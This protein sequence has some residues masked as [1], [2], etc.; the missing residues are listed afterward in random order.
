M[1]QDLDKVTFQK[2][3]TEKYSIPKNT[4]SKWKKNM[5]KILAGYKKGLDS[6]RIAEC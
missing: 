3:V 5:A 2:D 1:L 4:I 6:K